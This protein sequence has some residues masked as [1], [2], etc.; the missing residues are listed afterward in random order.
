MTS[1]AF[2]VLTLEQLTI[3]DEPSFRHVG[4]YAD[5]REVLVKARYPFRVMKPGPAARP[6]RALLLNLTYWGA[7]QGGDVLVDACIP[8]DVVAHAAWHHLAARAMPSPNGKPSVTSMFVGEAIASAFD[9]YLVGRLLGHA[10]DSGF[11]ESQ[12][13]RMADT[14]LDAGLSEEDFEELLQGLARDP[15]RAFTALYSLLVDATAALFGADTAE[16]GHAALAALDQR[17]LASLLHRFELSNWVL[18][19][20]AFGDASPDAR[21]TSIDRAIREAPVSLDWL[22]R[23]WVRPALG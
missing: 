5:L 14:A 18:Y 20:R 13:P 10:P 16:A 21:A 7:E 15:D 6:D 17:P 23:E 2:D 11:L 4:L 22:E 19:A 12:V 3:E 9:V 8:A 1:A